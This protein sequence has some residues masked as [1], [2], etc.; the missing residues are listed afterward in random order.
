MS[1]ILVFILILKILLEN[2]N[3]MTNLKIRLDKMATLVD[4]L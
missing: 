1:Q 4:V 3:L 2:E